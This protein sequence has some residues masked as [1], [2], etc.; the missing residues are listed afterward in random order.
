MQ[1]ASATVVANYPNFCGA[2]GLT[3]VG[4]T[5][6][7]SSCALR[8]T[9]AAGSEAGAAYSTTPITLGANATFSTKF[10]FQFAEPSPS[11]LP[12]FIA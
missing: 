5:T 2:T 1:L 10:T 12:G 11:A 3:L 6:T 4:S 8:L 9:G 7:S